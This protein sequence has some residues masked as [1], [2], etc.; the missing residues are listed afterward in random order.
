MQS[1]TGFMVTMRSGPKITYKCIIIDII[2]NEK[3]DAEGCNMQPMSTLNAQYKNRERA[4]K[5]EKSE[6]EKGHVWHPLGK[7]RWKFAEKSSA[8]SKFVVSSSLGQDI[9]NRFYE[10]S[11]D[12]T[13]FNCIALY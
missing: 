5:N 12:Y 9:K 1:K 4:K 10:S 8:R 2:Q 13:L 7:G 11:C 6:K 3:S